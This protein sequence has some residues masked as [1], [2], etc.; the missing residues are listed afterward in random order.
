V[1][2]SG[3]CGQHYK[4]GHAYSVFFVCNTIL[5]MLHF[6]RTVPAGAATSSDGIVNIKT[7][8]LLT[9]LCCYL[10]FSIYSFYGHGCIHVFHAN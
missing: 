4:Y 9:K 10:N 2:V 6:H 8:G 5:H 3:F 7:C 1:P